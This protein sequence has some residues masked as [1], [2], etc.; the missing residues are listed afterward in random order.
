M[1]SEKRI[2]WTLDRNVGDC[3]VEKEG[4]I[5]KIFINII[6]IIG[7]MLLA[8]PA[9]A[10]I[11]N[12]FLDSRYLDIRPPQKSLPVGFANLPT[13]S[14]V[15]KLASLQS[16]VKSQGARG[17]CSIFSAMAMYESLAI[18]QLGAP[19]NVDLSEEWLEYLIMRRQGSEGSGSSRNF[20]TLLMMSSPFEE[21]LPYIGETWEEEGMY[22]GSLSSVRCLG[23][24]GFKLKACLLG[25]YRPE[26]ME[27][28]QEELLNS[29]GSL[30]SPE[31]LKARVEAAQNLALFNQKLVRAGSAWVGRTDE[32]KRFLLA[33][34]PLTLD[35]DFYYGAWNHR[36]ATEKGIERN[37]QQWFG[38][39]VGH[40]EPG[41]LDE[42][43]SGEDPA[44]HSVLIVGYDDD[45]VIETEVP[46]QD[47]SVR[48]FSYMGVYYFKNSWG[49]DGFGRDTLIRGQAMPGYGMITQKYAESIGA[50]YR[51]PSVPRQQ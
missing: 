18:R 32:V 47:G 21:T 15:L 1:H 17:T 43:V 36:K 27:A 44:G 25:H 11:D 46:M 35:V 28:S 29:A 50:F 48:K 26:L 14:D 9:I 34:E 5:V 45:V 23:L 22:E 16:P 41:S 33:G 2:H 40:P 3:P 4:V 7:W 19:Q 12:A 39:I 6:L 8:R 49:M 10:E 38:G 24:I 51:F 31:F 42:K 20:S 30:Y 37:M 13:K